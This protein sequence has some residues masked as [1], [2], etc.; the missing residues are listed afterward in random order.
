M[1][2]ESSFQ[3]QPM[4]IE[5]E[6]FSLRSWQLSDAAKLSQHL[7]NIKI[8]NN[9]RDYLPHP[10]LLED[11]QSFIR[12]NL[13]TDPPRNLAI[14]F[15]DE[16]IGGLG[17]VLQDDVNRKNAELGYWLGEAYWN[18]GIAT[19]AVVAMVHYGLDCFD[20]HRIYAHVF[21]SNQRS[22]R[23]LEKAGFIKEGVMR[24]A[25]YKNAAFQDVH[26]YAILRSE[27]L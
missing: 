19:E 2:A 14:V 11:A 10:Y 27:F 7:N 13:E 26:I 6:R 21:S 9:V 15:N 24:E 25:V 22:M 23:V 16:A 17:L 5:K 4:I 18:M 8:W 3:I 1:K 12:M 20:L